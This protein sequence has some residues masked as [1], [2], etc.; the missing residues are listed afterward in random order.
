MFRG[1]A[2]TFFFEKIKEEESMRGFVCA[3]LILLGLNAVC[4]EP[5]VKPGVAYIASFLEGIVVMKV[6][7]GQE[8]KKGDLLFEIETDYTEIVLDKCK[9]ALWYYNAEYDRIKR[10]SASK[11]KCQDD[12][13]LAKYNLESAKDDVEKEEVLLKY[14][15]KYYAP[16]NGVVTEIYNYTGSGV[17]CGSGNNDHFDAVLVLTRKA[18]FRKMQAAGK[19]KK[20]KAVARMAP[21]VTGIVQLKAGLGEKVDAGQVLFTIDMRY[22]KYERAQQA[23]KLKYCKARYL[24]AKQLYKKDSYSQKDYQYSEFELKNAIQDYKGSNLIINRRSVYKAPFAGTVTNVIHYTGSNVF[25]GHTV[26]EVSK[27]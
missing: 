20:F 6:K 17:S 26:L 7:L 12:L 16:F 3:V 19:Y 10:L 15:S 25:S 9:N 21:M 24:R 4:A 8:V 2:L 5:E 1:E 27:D 13:D 23:A 14:W 18:D 11:S 22:N